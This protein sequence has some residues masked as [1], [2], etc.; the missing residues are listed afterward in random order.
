M[1]NLLLNIKSHA[2]SMA[3]I[4]GQGTMSLAGYWGRAPR[5]ESVIRPPFLERKGTKNLS[6]KLRFSVEYL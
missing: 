4:M 3:F 2:G 5:S 6:E 1:K